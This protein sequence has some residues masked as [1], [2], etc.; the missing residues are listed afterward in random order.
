MVQVSVLLLTRDEAENI[1]ACL[2]AIYAQKNPKTF[3]VVVVDSG[4]TDGTTEIAAR[5]PV[6]LEKIRPEQ[7]HHARTR[8]LAAEL[9]NGEYLVYLAADAI[10]TSGEWLAALLGNFADAGVAAV[11][12]RHM[13]KPNSTFERE[14]TLEAVY[15]TER[16]V[17]DPLRGQE[18]GYRYFHFSTV[19]ASIR[20]DVWKK[21]RFPEDLK[22]YED[23]GI[24]KRILES[25]GKIVYEPGAAVFHSHNH[26]EVGLF[27]RYF[28]TGVIW[29]QL[30]IWN[31]QTKESMLKDMRVLLQKKLRRMRDNSTGRPIGGSMRRDLAKAIGLLLGLNEKYIPLSVKRHF[32]AIGLY[33]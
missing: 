17:K 3:E 33:E 23:V 27:Q 30:G 11:Y 12:G 31:E 9:A 19:N 15:G 32:S 16:L 8:N 26:S 2:D 6:R 10:P 13:P 22:C 4:S 24:A 28:D 18:M 25:G 21:T 7:F 29:R 5:Y 14:D 20:K 1:A